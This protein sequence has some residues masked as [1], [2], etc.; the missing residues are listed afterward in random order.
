M[1]TTKLN[2]DKVTKFIGSTTK[3]K[4]AQ[5]VAQKFG[6]AKTTASRF[7]GTMVDNQTA[8]VGGTLKS[9][10]QGRPAF[11]YQPGAGINSGVTTNIYT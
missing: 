4:T 5:Q 2:E 3:G 9:G 11:L 8:K 10:V 1:N 7:L 6:V